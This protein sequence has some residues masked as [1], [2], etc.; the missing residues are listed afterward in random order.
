MCAGSV[1]AG[2]L[3]GTVIED[4]TF[5]ALNESL[6]L[7]VEVKKR[8][9]EGLDRAHRAGPGTAKRTADR[10]FEY[11]ASLVIEKRHR[12]IVES[13]ADK[14]ELAFKSNSIMVRGKGAVRGVGL[15]VLY[16]PAGNEP[17]DGALS[18]MGLILHI[19]VTVP[20][21]RNSTKK[22][23]EEEGG[24]VDEMELLARFIR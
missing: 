16:L 7:P 8:T 15:T 22:A 10:L 23:D 11:W 3:Y 13:L 12:D 4:L 6:C 18:A 9:G 2:L 19:P 20:L 14:I 21:E 17:G 5:A 1:S 24:Q